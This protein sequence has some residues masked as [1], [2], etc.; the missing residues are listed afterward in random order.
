MIS[1][2]IGSAFSTAIMAFGLTRIDQPTHIALALLVPVF[3][4]LQV[5]VAVNSSFQ[6]ALLGNFRLAHLKLA[7]EGMVLR[8]FLSSSGPSSRLILRPLACIGMS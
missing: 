2:D 6:S 8:F 7:A 5:S 3:E 4:L 1:G